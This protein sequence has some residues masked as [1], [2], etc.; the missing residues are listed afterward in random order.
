MSEIRSGWVWIS[1]MAGLVGDERNG[2]LVMVS[3]LF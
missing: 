2:S 1:P 3:L